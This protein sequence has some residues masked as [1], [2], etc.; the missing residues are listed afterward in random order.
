MDQ[1]Y[2]RQLF[3]SHTL[4]RVFITNG[5]QLKGYIDDIGDNAII[6]ESEKKRRLIYKHA[7]STIEPAN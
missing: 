2:L 4:V 3:N 6:L 5:F 1:N 7:I